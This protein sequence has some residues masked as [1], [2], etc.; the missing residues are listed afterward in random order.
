MSPPFEFIIFYKF[1]NF[2]GQNY[3]SSISTIHSFQQE[4][5]REREKQREREERVHLR[6]KS[7][8][9]REDTR[10]RGEDWNG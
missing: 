10:E 3:M 1:A 5:G 8:Q 7:N 2:L 6:E 4:R 9:E